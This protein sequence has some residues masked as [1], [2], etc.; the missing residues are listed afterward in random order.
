MTVVDEGSLASTT[1]A[2]DAAAVARVAAIIVTDDDL[3]P[4]WASLLSLQRAGV[5]VLALARSDRDTLLRGRDLDVE[6]RDWTAHHAFDVVSRRGHDAVLMV[7]G[8]VV[9]PPDAFGPALGFLDSG[10]QIASV[11]FVSNNAGY[12][13]FPNRN[14]PVGLL[15]VGHDEVSLTAG[16]RASARRT[17]PAPIAVPAGAAVLIPGVVARTMGGLDAAIADL[18]TAVL[19]FGLRAV[20]RG[21]LHVLDSTTFITTPVPYESRVDVRDDHEVRARLNRSH[22]FFPA[23]YDLERG[24]DQ[25]PLADVLNLRKSE[26][27]GVDVLIDGS[28]FG[29][30][31]QGTQVAVLA[32][33]RSLTAHPQI[34]RVI[35]AMPEPTLPPAYTLAVLHHPKVTLCRYDGGAIPDAPQVDVI[36]RPYQPHGALPLSRWQQ[37]GRRL[38]VTVQDLIAYNNGHYHPHHAEWLDYRSAMAQTL[39]ELDAVVTISRDTADAVHD[40]GILPF[41]EKLT[42]VPNGTDHLAAMHGRSTPP[43]AFLG[44]LSLAT[45]FALVLGTNYAHKNRDLAIRAWQELRERGHQLELVMAGVVV[46]VGSTRNEEALAAFDGPQPTVLPDVTDAER[47]WLLE[48][49]TVVLY[50]TT[51]EGFGLVPFEAAEFGTPTVFVGFGPLAE[52]LDGV[53]VT[54]TEWTPAAFADAVG[55][56]DLDPSLGAAQVAA[57][58]AAAVALTWDA[59]ADRLVDVYLDALSR[60]SGRAG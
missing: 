5:Q 11:S 20:S 41:D 59:A 25:V 32:S 44:R 50:P 2:G 14:N 56:I 18:D 35:V 4:W 33:I 10:A 17:G 27:L 48:H 7:T 21:F 31:E 1:T 6:V 22:P 9:V 28:C 40:A 46:P 53:P 15:P 30:F 45:R 16:L 47:N 26:L 8:P 39:L 42:V 43:P 51:A 29:P 58:R 13:S 24:S 34:R 37:V 23:L 36:H 12:L 52:F 55:R 49:A 38:V 54:A 3:G 19:E 57:V 60:P